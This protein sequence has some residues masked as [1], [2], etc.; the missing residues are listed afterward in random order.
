MAQ[1]TPEEALR[2]LVDAIAEAATVAGA[3]R[4][5]PFLVAG[6]FGA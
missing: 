1:Q 2:P 5:A 3:V 4:L 6:T